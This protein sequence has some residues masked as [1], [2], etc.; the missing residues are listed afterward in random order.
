MT[1]KGLCQLEK[2]AS[3]ASCLLRGCA[4]SYISHRLGLRHGH[5]RGV[6]NRHTT[7]KSLRQRERKRFLFESGP[8][9]VLKM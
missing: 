7:D 9:H 5:T 3:Q 4:P 2:A 8:I 1:K 6:Q